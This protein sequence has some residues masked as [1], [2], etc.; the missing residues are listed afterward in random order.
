MNKKTAF[1]LAAI[2]ALPGLPLVA[3]DKTKS[4]PSIEK[5]S[6]AEAPSNAVK[7]AVAEKHGAPNWVIVEEDFWFPLR[8]EPLETLDA[9]RYQFRRNEE[10]AAAS[11][12]QKAISWL[13]LAASHAMPETKK[14][15]TT[16]AS[17]LKTVA[18][19]LE[20]G[21]L[22]DAERFESALRQASHALATWHYFRAKE[23]WGKTEA[24]DAGHDLIMAAN[25]LQNAAESARFEYG[26]KT[27]EV[28]TD[29]FKNGKLISSESHTEHDWV[30]KDLEGVEGALKELGTTLNAVK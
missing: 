20:S 23:S 19:D 2:L 3:Q 11:E 12:I 17:E 4:K 15:L 5:T 8:F 13:N 25:Y 10:K 29:I 27:Q 28:I 21:N 6:A 18:R 7:P 14:D 30:L 26:P 9:A 24:E 16:A 22:N 1:A